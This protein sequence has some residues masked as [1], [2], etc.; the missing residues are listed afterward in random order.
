MFSLFHGP[1]NNSLIFAD[2]YNMPKMVHKKTNAKNVSPAKMSKVI[3]KSSCSSMTHGNLEDS[4]TEFIFLNETVDHH[5]TGFLN[6]AVYT[7]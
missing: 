3:I 7:P 1:T 4:N 5:G 2:T 6:S